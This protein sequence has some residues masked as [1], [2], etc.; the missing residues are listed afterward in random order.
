V[1]R[2]LGLDG[3]NTTHPIEVF[4][5]R[6]ADIDEVFD[7][8]S[9]SKGG[10]VLRMLELWLGEDGFRQGLRLYMRRHAFGNTA[11]DDLWN[12]LAETNSG[13][14]VAAVMSA[15][16]SQAGHPV[17]KCSC[18]EHG[19]RDCLNL[20]QGQFCLTPGVKGGAAVCWPIPL[21]VVAGV[22]CVTCLLDGA[23]TK[24]VLPEGALK[25]DSHVLVNR[26][27]SAF[28]RVA[29]DARLWSRL[30]DAV[31]HGR[32]ASPE[33]RYALVDDAAALSYAGLMPAT[34]L[35]DLAAAYARETEYPV[36]QGLL[37][38]LGAMIDLIEWDP[39]LQGV[40]DAFVRAL[41]ADV[42]GRLGWEP[43]P[44][45]EPSDAMLRASVLSTAVTYGVEDVIQE[46]L[47][48]FRSGGQ[49]DPNLLGT[50]Y[51]AV[52]KRGGT[53]GYEQLLT[54]YRAADDAE[55]KVR[56][57]SALGRTPD[58]VLKRRTLEFALS[59]E[60]RPQD[61]Y[62]P[63]ASVASTAV[64]AQLAWAFIKERW[65]E[66]CERHQGNNARIGY[67][68]KIAGNLATRED[69]AD[70]RDFLAAHPVEGLSL[71]S[72]QAL[73]RLEINCRWREAHA[74][75]VADWL[76]AWGA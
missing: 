34:A 28:C 20:E 37:E 29:Y 8:I 19:G 58:P 46:A 25:D 71:V 35:F 14:P 44:G 47:R 65:T 75:A 67:Y 26:G 17:I 70:A 57:L 39:N 45:E 64:G 2:A 41:L 4:I 42:I 68:L 56:L 73:E 16:T 48:R 10:S 54:R 7:A 23:G 18:G 11:S 38:S 69:L 30:V 22:D 59:K 32:I 53:D 52:A 72:A 24:Q 33:E 36:W 74:Q 76:A 66:I 61:A 50:I 51:E 13:C 6:A 55:A 12:A 3:Q 15:W 31:Q 21:S 63:I 9:Y 62:T 43:V 60:V 5:P 49:T 27:R 1:A 40:A